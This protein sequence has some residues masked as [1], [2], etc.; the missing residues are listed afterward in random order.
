M[1]SGFKTEKDV[2]YFPSALTACSSRVPIQLSKLA[3]KMFNKAL[4]AS[5]SA[6][7]D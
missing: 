7:A 5:D 1:C 6:L 3:I 2:G 4:C